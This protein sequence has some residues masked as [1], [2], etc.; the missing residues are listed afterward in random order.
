MGFVEGLVVGVNRVESRTR[1]TAEADDLI[2]YFT[3]RLSLRS[4]TCGSY[5][6][7]EEAR[8]P[9]APPFPRHRSRS[10]SLP[11][12]TQE[13]ASLCSGTCVMFAYLLIS[14]TA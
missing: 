4:F 14:V 10:G 11:C 13:E 3:L 7:R 5:L 12:F 8:I 1:G 9:R 2:R 6:L